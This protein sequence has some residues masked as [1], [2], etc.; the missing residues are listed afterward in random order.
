MSNRNSKHRANGADSFKLL[1]ALSVSL[2][3]STLVAACGGGAGTEALAPSTLPGNSD[4]TGPPPAT[5][6]VQAF[7]VELWSN[8]REGGTASCG[9]CHTPG[10][11][12]VG[13]FARS[14]DVNTA[15]AESNPRVNREQPGDSL[16]VTKLL[17]PGGHNCWLTS[18]QACADIMTNWIEAWVGETSGEGGR[19]IQLNAP[20]LNE[21]AQSK[22]WP[23]PVPAEFAGVH[24]LL[25]EYCSD[26]H[27]SDGS[28]MQQSPFFAEA[29]EFVAYDAVQAKINL[30]QPDDSRLVLRLREEFHNCWDIGCPA[31]AQAMEDA[32]IDLADPILLSEVDEDLVI[33][34]A[35]TLGEGTVA[36]GGNRY[37]NNL[38]ALWEFKEG[39]GSTIANDTS[40]VNPAINLIVSG[41]VEW[42]GGWG[43]NIK[44]GK[45]QGTT[46]DSRKLHDLIKATG[47]YAIE[48]WVAPGNV[49]QEESRIV[50][51][52]A[53]TTARNFTL[54][55]T[56]Y[57]YD[58]YNRSG[59]S[60]ANG[61]PVLT[62]SDDDEDLQ[63]TLQH[64]VA[65]YDPINGRQIYVNGEFTDDMDPVPGDT[66]ADWDDTFA[67]VSR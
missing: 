56:I 32:I 37:E 13:L 48:A 64:V 38:I 3:V 4:Y 62:T 29:D 49:T 11:P 36:S 58:F 53:G 41:D 6:D 54:G 63:A 47:E 25:T 44:D 19:T 43:L 8:T 59:S 27:A 55:Q 12:G 5:A 30:D 15:Y 51:Y 17:T 9:D 7:M 42:V 18:D 46:S 45:A 60:D 33:S 50:S 20:P 35:L 24:D 23:P 28:I 22:D 31:S 21:P 26:C 57:S 10:G 65:N 66:L 52:S 40:G 2:V 61:D 34:K 39:E 67:F 16:L 14:D 1:R